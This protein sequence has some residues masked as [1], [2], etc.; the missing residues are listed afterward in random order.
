SAEEGSKPSSLTKLTLGLIYIWGVFPRFTEVIVCGKGN[1]QR[2]TWEQEN[3]CID[4][5][6]T[7]NVKSYSLFSIVTNNIYKLKYLLLPQQRTYSVPVL[8]SAPH[9]YIVGHMLRWMSHGEMRQSPFA[10]H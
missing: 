4:F 7:W 9:S 3:V 5:H 1:S 2:T 10:G 6:M 8:P